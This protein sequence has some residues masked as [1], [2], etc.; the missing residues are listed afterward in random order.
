MKLLSSVS[1]DP[2]M[3]AT[4]TTS[5]GEV[6]EVPEKAKRWTYTAVYRLQTSMDTSNPAMD[7]QVKTGYQASVGLPV[8]PRSPRGRLARSQH[9]AD[10]RPRLRR[11]DLLAQG[12]SPMF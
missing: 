7:G 2:T 11:R 10:L 4:A 5:F 12:L 1:S 8:R 9:V 3:T 6:T